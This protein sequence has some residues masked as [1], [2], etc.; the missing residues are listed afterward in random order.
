M[1]GGIADNGDN[2]RGSARQGAAYTTD[3]RPIGVA[4]YGGPA[5]RK[6]VYAPLAQVSPNFDL[7]AT[8]DL[9]GDD[10]HRVGVRLHHEGRYLTARG[11]R[12]HGANHQF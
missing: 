3:R 9:C 5:E 7:P 4:G 12:G 1:A 2:W 10:E 6:E 11:A 8:A